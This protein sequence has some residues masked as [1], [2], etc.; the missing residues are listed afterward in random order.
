MASITTDTL[1]ELLA[2][3]AAKIEEQYAKASANWPEEVK[4]QTDKIKTMVTDEIT[5]LLTGDVAEIRAALEQS[6]IDLLKKGKG[7]VSKSLADLA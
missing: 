1:K 2:Q 5:T 3:V 4:S 6:V 7:P